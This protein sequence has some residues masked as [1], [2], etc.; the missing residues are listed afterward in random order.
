MYADDVII[1][2]SAETSVE[3]QMKLQLCVVNVH[4][5]YNMNRLTVNKKKSA[6]MVIGSKAQLQS[7]NL[8]QFSVNLDSDKIE[9]VNKAKYLGLFVKDDL[10]WDDHSLQLC[11]TMNYY[12]HVLRRLNKIFP[13]Q[14]LLEIYKSYVQSK[15]D[16]GLSIWGCTTEGNLDRVQRIQNFC[17]RIMWK[18][19]DYIH[20]RGIDLVN[21]LKIQTIRQRRDYFLSVLMFKA[22]HGLA[23][24]HLCNDVTMIVDV[25]GYNPRSSE[26]MNFYVPKYTKEICKLLR[27]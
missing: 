9:F 19:Y 27:I 2:T 5:W 24:H 20:T 4:Q 25:H 15:L 13:K 22:I 8:D 17:A 3:L 1:Y 12:V 11:K 10:S 21:S 16:Y 6:V 18:N 14:L 23:P 7:Q 26:N